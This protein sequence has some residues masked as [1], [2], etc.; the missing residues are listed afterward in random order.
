M[1]QSPRR[2]D[3]VA[4]TS[5]QSSVSPVSFFGARQ[6]A[7]DSYQYGKHGRTTHAA[8]PRRTTAIYIDTIAEGVVGFAGRGAVITWEDCEAMEGARRKAL[9]KHGSTVTWPRANIYVYTET[10]AGGEGN[11]HAYQTAAASW[12]SAM[13]NALAAPA[14]QTAGMLVRN[15]VA[16]TAW[17]LGCRGVSPLEWHPAYLEEQLNEDFLVEAW[18]LRRIRTNLRGIRTGA[19]VGDGLEDIKWR[20]D[21]KQ[22]VRRGPRICEHA[23]HVKWWSQARPCRYARRLAEVGI[24]WWAD[25]THSNGGQWMTQ[26][27]AK[28]VYPE[29]SSAT[30]Q[31]EYESLLGALKE[32]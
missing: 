21:L 6:N 24:V 7:S 5:N 13:D 31:N 11:N 17:R 4:T 16:A 12:M 19:P 22:E 25:V 18:Y 27:E 32:H 1:V 3:V 29:L 23:A 9:A 28:R 8:G 20:L 2:H 14:G 10:S 15:M 30:D 26:A